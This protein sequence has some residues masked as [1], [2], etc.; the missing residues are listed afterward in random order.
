FKDIN[1]KYGHSAGDHILTSLTSHIQTLIRDS[2]I[3]ARLG[4]EEFGILLPETNADGGRFLAEKIR[5]KVAEKT[6]SYESSKIILTIS[7]GVLT[8]KNSE[9]ADYDIIYKMC[10]NAMYEAKRLGKNRLVANEI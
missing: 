1:D 7:A 5:K 9:D 10:D 8:V 6:F 4:G 2:D 3:F